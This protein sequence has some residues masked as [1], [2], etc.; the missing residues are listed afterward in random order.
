MKKI[1]SLFVLTAAALSA[2]EPG[3]LLH[4]S[5]DKYTTIP[6]FAKNPKTQTQG[7]RPELQLRMYNGPKGKRNAVLLDNREC[8]G[9]THT[10]NFD[11]RQGTVSFWVKPVNWKMSTAGRFQ[12]FFEL[13]SGD[14]KYR[15]IVTKDIAGDLLRFSI[16]NGKWRGIASLNKTGWQTGEWHKIDCTWNAQGMKL[17]VDGKPPKPGSAQEKIFKED[18]KFPGSI[19]WARMQINFFSGWKVDPEWQTA[20]DDLK[21]YD[22]VLSP[23]EIRDE[24][25][26]VFPPKKEVRKPFAVTPALLPVSIPVSGEK[27]IRADVSAAFEKGSLVLDYRVAGPG[28]KKD[29]T[30][31]DG[32][33]WL[34]DAVEFH[35]LGADG[36][37]RQFIVNPAGTLYDSLNGDPKW[38]SKAKTAAGSTK[39]GW[40]VR[41]EIPLS[42]LGGGTRIAANFCVSNKS[43]GRG[44]FTWSALEPNKGF[45]DRKYFGDLELRE[46]GKPAGI[47]SLGDLRAGEIDI[48]CLLPDGTTASAELVDASGSKIESLKS[49][50]PAGRSELAVT[51]KDEKGKTVYTYFRSFVVNPPLVMNTR[52][53]PSAR[54]IEFRLDFSASGLK[55]ADG[56][57]SLC[58]DG[59][60]YS[61]KAFHADRPECAVDLPIPDDLPDNARYTLRAQAGKFTVE[62]SLFIPDLTPLRLKVGV[63][64]SV[65][66]PWVPV[67]VDGKQVLVL[68]RVYDFGSGPLPAQTV[69][70]GEKL[71]AAQPRFILNGSPIAWDG[72]QFGRNHGDYVELT[73]SGKFTGGTAKI[74]GE[75]W[76]DGMYKFDL[77]LTPSAPL[78]IK[79]LQL[80]WSM[81]GRAARYALTPEYTPWKNDALR[82]KWDTREYNSLLWLTGI[83]NG[84]AWWCRSDANWIIDPNRE[85]IVVERKDGKADIRIDMFA[86]PAVLTKTAGYT[87][88]FQATPPKHPDKSLRGIADGCRWHRDSD[89]V[90][91]TGY[92]WYAKV[93]PEHI[94]GVVSMVPLDTKKFRDSM[95]DLHTKGF[96]TAMYGMPV[97][98]SR[99]EPEYDYFIAECINRPTIIWEAHMP[100][101]GEAYVLEPCCGHTAIAD[102]HA[103][104]LDKI[105][106]EVPELDG[107]YFDIMHAHHCEN[108]HHGCGGIDAFGKKY[109]V[110][111][112]LNLRNYTLRVLKI[113]QKHD[114]FFGIHA[115]NAYYPFVHDLGDF[116]IPGEELFSPIAAN[117]EWGYMEA[118]SPEAFQS[119]WNREIRGMDIR[120]M[121][122]FT[123]IPRCIPVTPEQKKKLESAEYCV[124]GLAPSMLYD[125]RLRS[126]GADK[127]D[128][129]LF[130]LWKI[131]K[132]V[133]IADSVFHGYWI[134]PV[135]TSAPAVKTSWYAW[136]EGAPY[137]R[138]LAVVNIKRPAVKTELVIDWK[139]LGI[140]RPEKLKDLWSGKVFTEKEL[141]ESTLKGHN[142]MLLVPER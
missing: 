128:S 25:E 102:F 122:Q 113:H 52:V 14:T 116:W 30:T 6:D 58:R 131:R 112:A 101:T 110:S 59:K 27:T 50:L 48:R 2:A 56:T 31:R 120:S 76:F 39:D 129:P 64:H 69:S 124:H 21:I 12:T 3:L 22:R 80:C 81:P 91:V 82:L 87:M 55:Q 67:K 123:R 89:V 41:L 114:R 73:A 94:R 11:P 20:Y 142:F 121:L 35:L 38:D 135:T 61:S 78:E 34:D 54:R 75:V 127:Q 45:A 65:P 28:S 37:Q 60:I 107:C 33:L 90:D 68:D 96:K 79:S 141:A 126:F 43:G 66:K 83:E 92:S 57:V 130:K 93:T 5:F 10:G 105:Y 53:Y 111:G 13:R 125:Y 77:A 8:V 104:N 19:R 72:V 88:V 137:S 103:C 74:S 63:D 106:R 84:L 26:K 44:S 140:P 118:V 100:V 51:L 109:S 95:R 18:P 108:P 136:K 4:T 42:D 119:A 134:D 139:K 23:A 132:Q 15:L 138:M 117:P 133:K 97:H 70:R 47:E 29:I 9:Y 46:G 71:L 1:L 62:K 17:Y 16:A 115:H 86:K 99:F 98:T 7:I 24:Y 85:N 32:E 36:K 49:A 40:T